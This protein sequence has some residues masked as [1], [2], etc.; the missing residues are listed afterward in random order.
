MTAERDHLAALAAYR[1]LNPEGPPFSTLSSWA[2]GMWRS[3]F[4]AARETS[5]TVIQLSTALELNEITFDYA[6]SLLGGTPPDRVTIA[7]S[8][9]L[10]RTV[11]ELCEKLGCKAIEVPPEALKTRFT[12]ILITPDGTVWSAPSD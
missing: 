4:L 5:P 9:I 12:W 1:V 2:Q 6:R 8:A 7:A 3:A 11:R 10:G